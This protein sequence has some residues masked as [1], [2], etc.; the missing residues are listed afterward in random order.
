MRAWASTLRPCAGIR[1]TYAQGL[2]QLQHL[3]DGAECAQYLLAHVYGGKTVP[4]ALSLLRRSAPLSA[5][6]QALFGALCAR[7]AAREPLQYILGEWDFAGLRDVAVRAPTLCP[8][9]E[10]EDLVALAVRVAAGGS[11]ALLDVGTGSGVVGAAML[12]RLPQWRGVGIDSS[13]A[14]CALAR[15]NAARAGVAARF[16]I[17]HADLRAYLPPARPDLVVSNPPYIPQADLAGLAP[18]V[19][20]WE[21]PAALAGGAPRGLGL[22]LALL[23]RA[24]GAWA[25]A[26]GTPLLLEVD[27]THPA[28][29]HALLA[30][31]A[32]AQAPLLLLPAS[33]LGLPRR[34]SQQEAAAAPPLTGE[35]AAQAQGAM[36]GGTL[37]ALRDRVAFVAAYSSMGLPRIVHLQ[38]SGER[39]A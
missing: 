34:L 5:R 11:G 27:S 18:E 16:A 10:T 35:E 29:L 32:Q 25:C 19:A 24:A 37:A 21:D 23:A 6:Q 36:A 39:D 38:V 3:P 26:P 2:A 31:G 1:Q 14:A 30:R 22:T 8:R 28:L 7:R 12:A 4:F 13:A 33:G 15:E 9:P 17:A 20:A